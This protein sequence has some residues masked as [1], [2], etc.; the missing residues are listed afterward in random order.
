VFEEVKVD[1]LTNTVLAVLPSVV[2]D[3]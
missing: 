1:V 3:Q 2:Y